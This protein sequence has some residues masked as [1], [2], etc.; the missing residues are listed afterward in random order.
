MAW[1]NNFR[2]QPVRV[3]I[4]RRSYLEKAL[5]DLFDD[6]GG[7]RLVLVGGHGEVVDE[8]FGVEGQVFQGQ[9]VVAEDGRQLRIHLSRAALRD[10]APDERRKGKGRR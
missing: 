3:E 2:P 7:D 4:E 8:R 10:L 5:F 9:L 1:Q 6:L